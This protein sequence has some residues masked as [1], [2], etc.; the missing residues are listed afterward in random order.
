MK[1]YIQSILI[2]VLA[3]SVNTVKAQEKDSTVNKSVTVTREF[4]PIIKDVGKIISNPNLSEPNL[5]KSIPNYLDVTTPLNTSFN[6]HHLHANELVHTPIN[7]KKGFARIGY[8]TPINSLANFSYPLLSDNNNRLDFSLDH[9]GSFMDKVHSNTNA[10]LQYNHLFNKFELYTLA[11]ASH[12]YFNYYGRSFSN[13]TPV[14]LSDFASLYPNI[15]F[16][17]VGNSS[18]ITN[19]T[20]LSA[21]PQFNTLWR[22]KGEAG[23]RSLPL[24]ND[25][26]HFDIGIKYK[27]FQGKNNTIFENYFNLNAKFT[28]PYKLNRL[29]MNLE[30]HYLEENANKRFKN[31]NYAAFK[32][33][34]HYIFEGEKLY[35]KLGVKTAISG[36]SGFT[37]TPSPDL[38]IQWNVWEEYLSLYGVATGD[39]T[40]NSLDKIYEE[41]RYISPNIRLDDTY[42]PLDAIAGIKLSPAYN[43]MIDLY[44]EFKYIQNQYYYR[45]KY[46]VTGNSIDIDNKDFFHNRFDISYSTTR[47]STAGARIAWNFKELISVYAKGAYHFWDTKEVNVYHAWL[48]PDW[49]ADFGANVKIFQDWNISSQFIFQDGRYARLSNKTGTKMEPVMD[50]NLSASYSYRDWLSFFVKGNNLLNKKYELLPGY[51]VQGINILGGVSFSF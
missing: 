41:N 25:K 20:N 12:D 2:I 16:A 7:V 14:I 46:Y 21:M 11:G 32:I 33:A 30:M 17:E 23:I 45:N 48:M 28:V 34:P 10:K 39:L 9:L 31:R 43:L 50:L 37:L 36:G 13:E 40:I 29:G 51:D 15:P 35:M 26:L 47:V 6:I 49:D 4:K 27:H 44:G 1:T 18:N 24:S 3:L 19:L 8:G 22:V 38:S 42:T 5:Q